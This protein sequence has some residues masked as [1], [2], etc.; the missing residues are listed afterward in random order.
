MRDEGL[1]KILCKQE[2]I[3]QRY[4]KIRDIPTLRAVLISW[5]EGDGN[6]SEFFEMCISAL[7]EEI[8]NIK[9][10]VLKEKL[11]ATPSLQGWVCPNCGAGK[12][13]YETTCACNNQHI[14]THY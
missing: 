10:A 12:S 1:K 8:E 3:L 2:Y 9:E 11:E 13:P 14:I 4:D 7:L 5:S 6:E